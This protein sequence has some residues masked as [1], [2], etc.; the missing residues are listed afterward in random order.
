MTIVRS[1]GDHDSTGPSGVAD[2]SSRRANA[3]TCPEPSNNDPF[4]FCGPPVGSGVVKIHLPDR[5]IVGGTRSGH[6]SPG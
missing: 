4:G 2:Q 6:L 3:R 1:T 5:G